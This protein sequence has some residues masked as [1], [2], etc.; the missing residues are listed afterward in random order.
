MSM[1]RKSKTTAPDSARTFVFESTPDES[2]PLL[3][4]R[5]TLGHNMRHG[6]VASAY[7]GCMI[8]HNNEPLELM[9]CVRVI[10]EQ[11]SEAIS[12]DLTRTSAMLVSQA[13]TLDTMFTEMARR[14]AINLGQYPDA[15]ER[16]MRLALKAQSNSRMT[17]ETLAKLHQPR[18]QTVRH[19]HVNEGGQAIVADTF[20]HHAGGQGNAENAKQSHATGTA[21]QSAA[22]P[23]SDADRDGVPI[24]SGIGAATVPDARRD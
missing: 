21:G 15:V 14:A 11:V 7:A 2:R 19:V 3:V 10:K 9:E 4:A 23:C 20:H 18:E 5:A 6:L 17:L 22:L 1:A 8:T 13:L 16:Y 12:G 24:A